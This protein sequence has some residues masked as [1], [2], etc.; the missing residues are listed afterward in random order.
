LFAHGVKRK[1]SMD[2]EKPSPSLTLRDEDFLPHD[3]PSRTGAH[4]PA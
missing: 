2:G 3:V 4:V 1:R